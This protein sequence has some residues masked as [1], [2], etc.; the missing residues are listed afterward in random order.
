MKLSGFSL[1]ELM[2]VLAI[3][4]TLTVLSFPLYS[5]HFIRAKRLEAAITLSKLAVALE[6]YYTLHNTYQQATL[7]ILGFPEK[8]ADNRYQLQI[9]T[10]TETDFRVRANPFNEQA[11]L[12]KRCGALLLNSQ[13]EK[14]ITGPGKLLDCWS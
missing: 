10:A 7:A 8:I 9:I 11:K 1:L 3:I 6:Q 2:I 12:D 13:G 5:Q 14:S 4:S